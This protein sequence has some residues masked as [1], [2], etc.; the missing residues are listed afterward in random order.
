MATSKRPN[1]RR[2]VSVFV[3]AHGG[4]LKAGDEVIATWH[5]R[6]APVPRYGAAMIKGHSF[7]TPLFLASFISVEDITAEE[8]AHL[9]EILKAPIASK[10]KD[11][12]FAAIHHLIAAI[13]LSGQLPGWQ[14]FAERLREIIDTKNKCILAAQDLIEMTHPSTLTAIAPHGVLTSDQAVKNVPG[15]RTSWR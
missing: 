4:F 13:A 14:D 3:P 1:T 5:P 2:K 11:K 8:T 7:L 6:R 10:F 9:Q 12:I 15:R